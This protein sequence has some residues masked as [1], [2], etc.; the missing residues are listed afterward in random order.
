MTDEKGYVTI[1]EGCRELYESIS[2][3]MPSSGD[4]EYFY[5]NDIRRS[6]HQYL[7]A[8]EN[9]KKSVFDPGIAG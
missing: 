1:E 7:E 5:L 3:V 4:V 9:V 2:F 8:I 6:L